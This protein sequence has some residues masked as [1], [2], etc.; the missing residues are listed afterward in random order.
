MRGNFRR[1][2]L[3]L[4]ASVALAG[5]AQADGWSVMPW[6]HGSQHRPGLAADGEGG[7]W[8]AFKTGDGRLG[9]ARL[10][11]DG[12]LNPDW[13][14]GVYDAGVTVQ[15]GSA[16]RVLASGAG[17]MAVVSDLCNDDG[18][19]MS[20]DGGGS[21]IGSF[22]AMVT[23]FYLEPGGVL[24]SDDRVLAAATAGWN[25]RDSGIRY[26]VI[27]ALGEVLSETDLSMGVQV[28]NARRATV[29]PDGAGGMYVGFQMFFV[30]DYS[31]GFDL[32]LLRVAGDGTR[33]WP[34]NWKPVCTANADQDELCLA[35]DGAGGI[36][37]S[38]TDRRT[39]ASPMDIY[40]ARYTAA[41]AL[42]SGWTSQGKRVTSAAGAQ[43]A[44]RLVDDGAGGAWIVW[45]DERVTDIDLYFTHL[46][47]NGAFAAG[48]SAAGTLLCD[49]TGAPTE[50]QLVA[51]GAGG[52]FAVWLDPRDGEPDLYGMHVTSAGTPAAGW[53]AGGLALC[54]DPAAQLQPALV[55]TGLERAMV[56]WRDARIDS[57]LVMTLALER[58][59]PVARTGVPPGTGESL[60]LRAAVNPSS[61][62]AEL[63]V[64]APP[65][66][67]VELDLLDV[68]GRV[69]RR[70]SVEG[71]GAETRV[72]FEGEPL[73]AGLYF[74]TA[75][76]G[77]ERA[78][79]RV[80][81]LR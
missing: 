47:G 73:P 53:P 58:G 60:R 28:P 67:P 38:W 30:E 13:P 2:A 74:A 68:A 81:V 63:R 22:P 3:A 65:G 50:P 39:G 48:F 9:L 26:A 6:F 15:L 5:T 4:L 57:G 40:A 76:R 1:G 61:G 11:P 41:G 66:G 23:K 17:R 45:R 20:Y 70:A 46:L 62:L 7:A 69:V 14:F 49:A 56:A 80:C 75:R 33:P 18:L 27:S 21:P 71:A 29:V 34:G 51:D 78:S 24:G 77:G 44:S 35:P 36:L 72:R 52:F 16:S 55:S 25:L 12:R 43:F 10:A 64:M 42:A 32:G 37:L 54:D 31:T 59:G 8:L 79:A 19:A